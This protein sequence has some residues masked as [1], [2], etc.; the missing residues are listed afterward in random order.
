MR[1]C[2][3]PPFFLT[4]VMMHLSPS[5][6]PLSRWQEQS[7]TCCYCHLF[8]CSDDDD[9]AH[10]IPLPLLISIVTTDDAPSLSPSSSSWWWQLLVIH[11]HSYPCPCPNDDNNAP[12]CSLPSLNNNDMATCLHPCPLT[13]CAPT[14]PPS[15]H[16]RKF[17]YASL[18]KW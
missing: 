7:T 9:N 5:L 13:S 8:P 14:F 2:P 10:P 12:S 11:F 17:Q 4:T 16:I 1:S 3:H 15:L 18:Q 6:P